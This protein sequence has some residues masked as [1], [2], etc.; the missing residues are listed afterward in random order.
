MSSHRTPFSRRTAWELTPNRLTIALEE[1]RRTSSELFDLTESNPTHCGLQYDETAILGSLAKQDSLEYRPQPRG[2]FVARDAVATYYLERGEASAVVNTAHIIMTTSTSEA[3]SFLFQLLCDPGDEVLVPSPSYPLFE[4]LAGLHDVRLVPYDLVYDH[5]WEIDLHG[6][7][8][9]IVPNTRA[10]LLVHPNNPTG[11]FVRSTELG[12]LNAMCIAR[13]LAIVSDEVFLDYAHDGSIH[14]SFVANEDALTFTL[15]GL[16]KISGLPQMKVAWM[17]ATG[18]EELRDQALAR[19]EVIADTYLSMNAPLQHALPT[20]LEQRHSIQ[21]QLLA[22]ISQNLKTLDRQLETMGVV[23]R[24][25]VQGG[26]YCVLRVPAHGSD[27]DLAIALLA[28][29]SVLVHPGHFFG[30]GS[31]CYLVLSLIAPAE[32]FKEGV[33]RLLAMIASR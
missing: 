33:V 12:A 27:E 31:G 13:G 30:F 5:G 20:L 22:R 18:P 21:K 2:L 3:Y 14:R 15:S 6:V 17:V 19:L 32:V 9:A 28:E 29:S 10:I 4:F 16:S 23:E 11:S 7:Q 8:R 1:H 24:L 26:W 25:D